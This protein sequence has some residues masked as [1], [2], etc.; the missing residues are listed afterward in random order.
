VLAGI[1]VAGVHVVVQAGV[2]VAGA[3]GV[4]YAVRLV[5]DALG[6]V[7]AGLRARGRARRAVASCYEV[8]AGSSW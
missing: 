1:V 6:V 8:R 4:V 5:V 7:Y 3:L 2:V